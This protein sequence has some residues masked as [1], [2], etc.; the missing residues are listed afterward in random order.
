MQ[1]FSIKLKLLLLTLISL[2]NHACAAQQPSNFVSDVVGIEEAMLSPHYWTSKLSH[3]DKELLSTLQVTEQNNTLFA[4][5]KHMTEF[6]AFPE[7][8][9]GMQILKKIKKISKVPTKPRYYADG[10]LVSQKQ[11]QSYI[12]A[13]NIGKLQKNGSVPLAMVV[14]RSNMRTFPTTDRVYKTANDTN[15]DRFQET[16]LFPT[17]IVAVLHQSKDQQWYFVVSYNYSA[18]VKKADIAIGK[19]AEILAYHRSTNFLVVTA[20]K[21]FTT[22]NPE[23]ISVSEIQL[24]MGAR[25]ALVAADEI[26]SILAGQNTYSSYVI[27][28]PTHDNNSELAFQP[29]LISRNADVSLGYLPFTQKNILQQSFKFLGERYGWG[30]SFNARDCT[31]FVG[32]VYKSFGVM[33]PRNTGQ[34]ANS[35]QGETISFDKKASNPHKLAQ[36]KQLNVGDLIYIPGHVM[37][38]LG[39]HQG[40]PYIIHDVSGLSYF[41]ENGDYYKSRLNGVAITPLIP[42]QLSQEKSFLD[43]VYK[44]KKIK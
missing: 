11:W 43:K 3:G 42:L 39:F 44:I 6:S 26:P 8:L 18:W 12:D 40:E 30:H 19:R 23:T 41:K 24:E 31:G 4:E 7:Q 25:L 27:S 14:R 33:M 32:E 5:N 10:S 37:M 2:S 16:A 21:L 9:S 35:N 20:D 29:A 22:Y 1:L 17:E 38:V 13:T 36:I 15:L 34:Q 28:L